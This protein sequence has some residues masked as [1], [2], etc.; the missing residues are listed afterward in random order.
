MN[1]MRGSQVSKLVGISDAN[2]KHWGRFATSTQVAYHPCVGLKE[3]EA[4]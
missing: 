1:R 3:G 2:D 4:V